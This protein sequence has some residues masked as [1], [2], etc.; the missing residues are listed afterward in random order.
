[1]SKKFDEIDLRIMKSLS[2][3]CRKSTT[4]IAKEAGIS[5]PTAIARLKNLVENQLVD[6]GAKVNV[7]NMGFKMALLNLEADTIEA[8]REILSKLEACPRV[9]QLIQTIE[10]PCYVA[11]VSAENAET[12]LSTIE[13]LR[14][15]LSARIV[16]WQRAKPIIGESFDL[17]ILLEKC[18]LTPCGKKCGI[19]S[20][21]Q[22]L[23][24]VGCPATKNYKGPL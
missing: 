10:K 19:C 21:Y 11:L 24:C 23:E 5:R 3:D 6:F 15:V 7:I 20:N 22:E 2:D 9:L 17:K 13:C 1:M 14:D 8:K 12:L 18:D 16:A 4:Q